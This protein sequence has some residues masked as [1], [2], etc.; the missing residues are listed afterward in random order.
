M[1]VVKLSEVKSQLSKYVERVR[2]GERVRILSRGVPVADLLPVR[3]DSD[4]EMHERQL[5]ELESLGWV[6]RGTGKIAEELMRP[7]PQSAG[8]PT[9]EELVDE[10]QDGR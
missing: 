3:V 6:R 7:G 10:R 4:G 2:R 1:D 9:S 5:A 8:R